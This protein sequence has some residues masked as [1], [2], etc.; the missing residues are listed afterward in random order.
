M[1]TSETWS[2]SATQVST[3]SFQRLSYRD[4]ALVFGVVAIVLGIATVILIVVEASLAHRIPDAIPTGVGLA[5]LASFGAS[6][7]L[8]AR[9]ALDAAQ[10]AADQRDKWLTAAVGQLA[11]QQEQL[12]TK[13]DDA[14]AAYRRLAANG[15]EEL[16]RGV[17]AQI[18]DLGRRAGEGPAS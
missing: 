10:R 15:G 18:F 17:G 14:L 16:P 6:L 5:S 4:R 9:S 2:G 12:S 1:L 3:Q 11:A 8:W 7:T 13:L